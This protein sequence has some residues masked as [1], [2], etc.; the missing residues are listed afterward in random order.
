MLSIQSSDGISL[1][2][3][4]VLIMEAK[5]SVVVDILGPLEVCSI[6]SGEGYIGTYCAATTLYCEWCRISG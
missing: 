3:D 2:T 4:R 6:V 1:H 5:S